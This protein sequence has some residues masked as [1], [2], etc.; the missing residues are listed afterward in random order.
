[1]FYELRHIG[2]SE[3]FNK[4]YGENFSY[5]LHLHQCFEIIV[6]LNGKMEVTVDN[7]KYDL[8]KGEAMFIFPNQIHSLKSEISEH[9]LCIFSHKL[10]A[11]FHSKFSRSKPV[12]NKFKPTQH[13][14]NA[15]NEMKID[16]SPFLQ[17]SVLYLACDE[18]LKVAKFYDVK[19]DHKNL[20]AEIFLFIEEN[21]TNECNLSLLAEKLEYDYSYLSRYFK[22]NV[23]ISFNEYVIIHRLN[24]VCY[25]MNNTSETILNCATESGFDSLRSFNR[26]FK[27]HFGL[28]P[29]QYLKNVKSRA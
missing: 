12:D 9:M 24:N 23:G 28:T 13:L 8:T 3:F 4:E 22:Q 7:K 19:S 14:I 5:P 16:S 21:Y 2:T 26:N 29:S 11:A 27:K 17:K 15:M 6:A 18:F 20:L 1:M 10:I 25:L